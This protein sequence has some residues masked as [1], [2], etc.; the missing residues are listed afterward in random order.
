[1]EGDAAKTRSQGDGDD[2]EGEDIASSRGWLLFAVMEEI[3]QSQR[4]LS[5]TEEMLD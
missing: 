2:D 5:R 1:M 4:K 3:R